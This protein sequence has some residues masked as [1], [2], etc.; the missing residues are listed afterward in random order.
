MDDPAIDQEMFQNFMADV[1]K[2]STAAGIL[3]S[4]DVAGSNTIG[5]ATKANELDADGKQ[6]SERVTSQATGCSVVLDPCTDQPLWQ[7]QQLLL[8]LRF[9]R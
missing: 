2:A 8:L 9:Q 3:K 1:N 7:Q 4:C 6:E 5:Q